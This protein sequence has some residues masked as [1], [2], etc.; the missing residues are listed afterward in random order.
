[1]VLPCGGPR[2][3]KADT[4]CV[5]VPSHNPLLPTR[6]A[7]CSRLNTCLI[8]PRIR[9]SLTPSSGFIAM[10]LWTRASAGL[11]TGTSVVQMH[12]T[13]VGKGSDSPEKAAVSQESPASHSLGEAE[14]LAWIQ[15]QASSLPMGASAAA[16]VDVAPVTLVSC[17]TQDLSICLPVSST[18]A[19]Q[20]QHSPTG[21][22]QSLWAEVPVLTLQHP[23][24]NPPAR[25]MSCLLG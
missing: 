22:Q 11:C 12:L 24:W 9:A 4:G 10:N 19:T 1:M 14:V 18:T 21:S 20:T 23:A 8:H 16:D 3:R 7:V 25:S 13:G 5:T 2:C 6:L 17:S 15:Y